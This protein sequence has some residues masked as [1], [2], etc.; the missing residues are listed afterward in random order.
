MYFSL[1]TVL[2]NIRLADFKRLAA[3]DRLTAPTQAIPLIGARRCEAVE[4]LLSL[5]TG[6]GLLNKLLPDAVDRQLSCR[7]KAPFLLM[8][9]C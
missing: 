7:A 2:A 9:Y 4:H 3:A 8:F 5:S 1:M 6:K